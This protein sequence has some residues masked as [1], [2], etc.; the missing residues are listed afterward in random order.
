MIEYLLNIARA[1]LNLLNTASPW[2]VVSYLIAGALHD[3]VPVEKLHKHLGNKSFTALFKVMVSGFVLPICSCGTVPLGVGMYYAGAYIGPVLCFM[4]STPIINPIALILSYGLLGKELTL[5]YCLIGIFL[6]MLIGW[7]ANETAGSE[8]YCP[9]AYAPPDGALGDTMRDDRS[10]LEK[11]KSGFLWMVNDFAL[12]ISKYVITGMLMAGFIMVTF[13]STIIQRYLGDPSALSLFNIALLATVMYVCA[14]GHIPFIAALIAA[15]ASP[16][17]AITFF[18]RGRVDQ[19][20]R[21][22]QHL[23]HDREAF[24][25]YLR[26]IGEYFCYGLGIYRQFDSAPELSAS[27]SDRSDRL[28]HS[29]RQSLDGDFP[30]ADPVSLFGNHFS[31]FLC[32]ALLQVCESKRG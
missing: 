21:A 26:R 30:G 19:Y 10:I 28:F 2:I 9:Q 3:I 24:R 12:V 29:E 17:S 14:I 27:D 6:P 25:N 11:L 31:F 5:I 8:L 23:S 16:G 20:R 4:T 13:P 32:F 15:G 18:G 1:S 22:S 7:I